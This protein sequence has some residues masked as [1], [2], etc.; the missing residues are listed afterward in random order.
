[1]NRLYLALLLLVTCLAGGCTAPPPEPTPSPTPEPA[2]T[3]P[4]PAESPQT[5]A[6][7]GWTLFTAQDGS[8]QVLLPG[9]AE[10]DRSEREADGGEIVDYSVNTSLGG[11]VYSVE[12]SQFPTPEAAKKA[13]QEKLSDIRSHSEG[14]LLSE[15]EATLDGVPGLMFVLEDLQGDEFRNVV[16][17]VGNRV[18][19]ILVV[20]QKGTDADSEAADR[21]VE[22]FKFKS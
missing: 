11:A 6:G 3:S 13:H 1:M 21:M 15:E 12:Y 19:D 9:P 2:H 17:L 22:S 4:T 20:P 8:F 16:Y 10:A 18:Y 7:A 5:G 14:K